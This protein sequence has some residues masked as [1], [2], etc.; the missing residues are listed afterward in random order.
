MTAILIPKAAL[1]SLRTLAACRAHSSSAVAK[2]LQAELTRIQQAV[3]R[4]ERRASRY[5]PLVEKRHNLASCLVLGV[6]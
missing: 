2:P 5:P 4:G 6:P 1:Q 3:G